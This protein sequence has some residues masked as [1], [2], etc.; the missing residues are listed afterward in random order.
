MNIDHDHYCLSCQVAW[1]CSD[2]FCHL[3]TEEFCPDHGGAWNRGKV[4]HVHE[5]LECDERDGEAVGIYDW[6]HTVANCPNPRKWHCERHRGSNATNMK[7]TSPKL[8][9]AH[10]S[11]PF[12]WAAQINSLIQQKKSA[13]AL[14]ALNHLLDTNI[15]RHY[16]LLYKVRLLQKLGRVKEAIA[17]VCLE[18]ELH[19]D[20]PKM[21]ALKDEL[22]EFYPYSLFD[23][24]QVT[25]DL[26]AA[27]RRTD[28]EWPDVAG[29]NEVKIQLH[30]DII[31]PIRHPERFK[32]FQIGMPNGILFYGPPGCGKTFLAR[33]IAAK[34]GYNF[35]EIRMSD[36]GSP[37]IHQTSTGLRQVFEEAEKNRPTILFLDE[38]DSLASNRGGH[39]SFAP[40]VEEVNELLKLM[41]KCS[42]RGILVIAACNSIERLDPAITRP[43]RFDKRIY[44]GPP[45]EAARH[46]LFELFLAS[47]PH[48]ANVDFD[49][50]VER[51]EGYSN[52]DI[53][54]VTK[55]AAKFAAAEDA[56][57]ITHRHI[58]E[59]LKV[60]PSSLPVEVGTSS[61]NRRRLGFRPPD[62]SD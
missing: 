15:D 1:G 53:E 13:A 41:D 16:V 19:P 39:D 28:S 62:D 46:G 21:L 18:S 47:K 51:T 11:E 35:K 33:K 26:L 44:V 50:L 38:V 9:I 12:W 6:I 42:D 34:V 5:C 25:P 56:S 43:G 40:R 31:L 60:I 4:E 7:E 36:V 57:R 23:S 55:Q 22:M 3:P 10:G 58:I 32:R 61:S 59:A 2:E 54:E 49:E 37:Y 52:A 29:M 17:W 45:D 24:R 20:E 27:F 30:N 14:R 8:P 48:S